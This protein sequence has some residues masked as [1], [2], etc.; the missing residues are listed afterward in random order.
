[1]YVKKLLLSEIT[2]DRQK[3]KSPSIIK[4]KIGKRKNSKEELKIAEFT[5]DELI[6]Q[7]KKTPVHK[8]ERSFERINKN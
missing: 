7:N 2:K 6:P 5:H 4:G 1:M 8:V 3:L